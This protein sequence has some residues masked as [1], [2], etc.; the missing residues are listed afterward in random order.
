MSYKT[1][2]CLGRRYFPKIAACI[3]MGRGRVGIIVPIVIG[4]CWYCLLKNVLQTMFMI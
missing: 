1:F 4:I 3:Y 2:N